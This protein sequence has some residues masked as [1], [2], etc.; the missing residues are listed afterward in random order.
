MRDF[1]TD[2]SARVS[3]ESIIGEG[4]KLWRLAHVREL[5]KVG[6]GS[7]I[8]QGVYVGPGVEIGRNCKIQNYALIYEP[9]TVG[10]GVFIGPGAILTNDLNP[11]AITAEG[12]LQRAEDWNAVGVVVED[13]ASIGAG[14]VC[15]APVKIGAWA[16]IAAGSVVTKDV[17]QYALVMGVPAQQR[18]WVGR[19]GR[20]LVEDGEIWRCPTSRDAYKIVEGQMTAIGDQ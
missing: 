5:A 17:P 11:R 20:T 4:A 3:A 16:M 15:V 9:S 10:D 13:G 19:S 14:A 12:N 6:S 18:G 8:G 1:Y 7:T 2:D